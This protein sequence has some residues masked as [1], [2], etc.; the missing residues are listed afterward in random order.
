MRR[1]LDRAGNADHDDQNGHG[2]RF[3]FPHGQSSFFD[4]ESSPAAPSDNGIFTDQPCPA[5]A[6]LM[7]AAHKTLRRCG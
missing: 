4:Q 6:G 1:I 3:T 2:I 5:R 7:V